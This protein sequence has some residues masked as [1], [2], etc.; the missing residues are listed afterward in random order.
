MKAG[1]RNSPIHNNVPAERSVARRDMRSSSIMS[2]MKIRHAQ[3]ANA[4][5]MLKQEAL[6][7]VSAQRAAHEQAGTRPALAEAPRAGLSDPAELRPYPGE[8]SSGNALRR[9]SAVAVP[10]GD[11][12]P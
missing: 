9:A 3:T 5:T 11:V 4:P 8:N 1:S 7:H 12:W 6:G 10:H 2:I